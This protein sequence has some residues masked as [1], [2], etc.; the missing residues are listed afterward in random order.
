[1]LEEYESVYVASLIIIVCPRVVRPRCSVL[2]GRQVCWKWSRGRAFFYLL[3]SMTLTVFWPYDEPVRIPADVL[4]WS[5][6]TICVAAVLP[7]PKAVAGVQTIHL[8]GEYTFVFYHRHSPKSLRFYAFANLAEATSNVS[9]P[10]D[11]YAAITAIDPTRPVHHSDGAISQTS[12]HQ[13]RVIV[14]P[15]LY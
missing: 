13:V 15:Q 7:C 11:G 12:I 9:S 3:S 5:D 8:S 10:R 2:R 1:M 6:P 4:G 14:P